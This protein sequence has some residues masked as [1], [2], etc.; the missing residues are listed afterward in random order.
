MSHRCSR[1][2]KSKKTKRE[3]SGVSFRRKISDRKAEK[4]ITASTS[5]EQLP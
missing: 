3:Q 5:D 1:S 2:L 4:R